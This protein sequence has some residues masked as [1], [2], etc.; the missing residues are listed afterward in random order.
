MFKIFDE[1]I[2]CGNWKFNL[3]LVEIFF[4]N[5]MNKIY[6]DTC[7]IS[8]LIKNDIGKENYIALEELFF[9][10]LCIVTSEVAKKEISK[11]PDKYRKEHENIYEALNKIPT[12]KHFSHNSNLMLMGVG[13]GRSD[14]P[15][16]ALLKNILPDE[17][18]AL[19]IFQATKNQAKNFITVDIRTILKFSDK[20]ADI[21]SMEFYTPETFMKEKKY[22]T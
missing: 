18:D 16:F 2:E 14:D 6:L 10:D 21:T 8:G 19:H 17:D 13:G 11:I 15:L 9:T 22:I 7:V 4:Y 12:I 1:R 20:L 5:R 3:T